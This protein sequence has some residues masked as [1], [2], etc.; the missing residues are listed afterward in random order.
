MI[1]DSACVPGFMTN[2]FSLE[3]LTKIN[4]H[5]NS[6]KSSILEISGGLMSFCYL[7]RNGS[8]WVFDVPDQNIA[9]SSSVKLKNSSKHRGKVTSVKAHLFMGH[10]TYHT[11]KIH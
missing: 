5:W 2:L 4:I 1:I 10:V 9:I 8:H 6:R 7:I 3:K 11:I